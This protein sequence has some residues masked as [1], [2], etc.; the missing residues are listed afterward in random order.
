MR[1]LVDKDRDGLVCEIMT[2]HPVAKRILGTGQEGQETPE[3]KTLLAE[4]IAGAWADYFIGKT[5]RVMRAPE[6]VVFER[7]Q[8][9]NRFLAITTKL[10]GGNKIG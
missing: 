2:E 7:N 9:M 4:I 10:L 1:G 5:S 6:D 8:M 3:G